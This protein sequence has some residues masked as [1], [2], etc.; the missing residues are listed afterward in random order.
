M[1]RHKYIKNLEREKLRLRVEQLEL[2]KQIR[3]DWHVLKHDLKPRNFIANKLGEAVNKN[4]GGSL[5][6]EA[7]NYGITFLG[8]KLSEKAGREAGAIIA[9][10]INTLTE[11]LNF[12]TRKK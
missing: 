1:K 4:S 12:G 7:I 5:F 11:K 3:D 6:S 8:H 2:E 10:G 9:K